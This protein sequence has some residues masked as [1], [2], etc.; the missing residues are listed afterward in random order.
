M[1]VERL[2]EHGLPR[3]VVELLRKRGVEELFPP[4]AEAVRRGLLDL[5]RNFVV[6][7]P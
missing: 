6:A 1:R 2:L 5:E 3:Q 4:Q 7:V